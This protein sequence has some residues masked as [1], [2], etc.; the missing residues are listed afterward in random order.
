MV[1]RSIYSFERSNE[2]ESNPNSV[3]EATFVHNFYTDKDEYAVAT[4]LESFLQ[5]PAFNTL[6]TKEQLGYIVRSS[7]S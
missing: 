7:L 4:V 2:V 5:E 1:D 6:R 3:C